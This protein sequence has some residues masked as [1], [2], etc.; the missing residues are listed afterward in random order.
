M[1]VDPGDGAASNPVLCG[2]KK[3]VNLRILGNGSV[4][5]VVLDVQA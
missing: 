2:A 3:T 5:R 1:L 4:I